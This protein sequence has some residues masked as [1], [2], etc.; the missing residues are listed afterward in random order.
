MSLRGPLSLLSI[1][2]CWYLTRYIYIISLI[3]RIHHCF[4]IYTFK[5]LFYEA[6]SSTASRVSAALRISVP[7][8][9]CVRFSRTHLQYWFTFCYFLLCCVLCVFVD[10]TGTEVSDF[11]K[12]LRE[13]A[14]LHYKHFNTRACLI[15]LKTNSRSPVSFFVKPVQTL[16]ILSLCIDTSLFQKIQI[17]PR[18]HPTILPFMLVC[19]SSA[20]Q[21][22]CH[23]ILMC[24]WFYF[25]CMVILYSL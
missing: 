18:S 3:L 13:I 23:N 14:G 21:Q 5:L 1:G 17:Q 9:L 7:L 22:A 25:I 15:T 4:A 19:L 11:R 12:R 8:C 24:P 20:W 16:N 2:P 6:C 10:W